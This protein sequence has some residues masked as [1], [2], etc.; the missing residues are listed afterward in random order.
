MHKR[1]VPRRLGLRLPSLDAPCMLVLMRES[2][3]LH[4]AR[5]AKPTQLA[6]FVLAFAEA[7]RSSSPPPS[8]QSDHLPLRALQLPAHERS[9]LLLPAQHALGG[10]SLAECG[11]RTR[12]QRG[13]PNEAKACLGLSFL[14]LLT[15]GIMSC[16]AEHQVLSSAPA[17]ILQSWSSSP[18]LT[19]LLLGPPLLLLVLFYPALLYLSPG[20]TTLGRDAYFYSTAAE[21]SALLALPKLVEE[22]KEGDEGVQL[23][24]VIPA[25]NEQDRLKKMLTETAGHLE[26]LRTQGKSVLGAGPATHTN[27][28]AHGNTP[29]HANRTALEG[30]L[31][32]YEVLVIDD[33]SRDETVS[34]AIAFAKQNKSVD[35]RVVKMG[36]N[37]GKG[38]AVRHGV[39]HTRGQLI[40]FCDADG[41]TRFADLTT[42]AKEM[43]RI[44]TSAGHGIVCGSRAH[45]V[46][47]EAVVKVGVPA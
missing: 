12:G 34:E 7:R 22:R 45:L 40:L 5:A 42:L 27:G 25:Y 36:K 16:C 28:G 14:L 2:T 37:C 26:A 19:T 43:S 39:L 47:S 18:Y 8:R 44:I 38:A 30:P 3:N 6:P 41:A 32:R 35:I 17:F 46:G 15:T 23:S 29:A 13:V 4:A 1:R 20:K 24:I 10:R 11:Q 31:E 9:H 33:G 21:P